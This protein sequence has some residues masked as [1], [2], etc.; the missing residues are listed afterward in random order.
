MSA[1][2]WRANQMDDL[3]ANNESAIL[4]SNPDLGTQW[5][6]RIT[7][8]GILNVDAAISQRSY[9]GTGIA[10]HHQ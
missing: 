3:I 6:N 10:H 4:T 2:T 8:S 5:M 1:L 7:V 9:A